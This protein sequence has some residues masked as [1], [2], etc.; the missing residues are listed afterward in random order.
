MDL[1]AL[2]EPSPTAGSPRDRV[3]ELEH[4][5]GEPAAAELCGELLAGAAPE[6]LDPA[7][8]YLAGAPVARLRLGGYHE[9]WFRVW[10][11]RGLLYVWSEGCADAV[12]GGL[13]DEHWRVA[14]MCLKVAAKRDL[15]AAA[16]AATRLTAHE[17]SRVRANAVRTLGLVGDTEHWETVRSALADPEGDVRRAAETARRRMADRLD[18]EQS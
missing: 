2:P 17:L 9:Y 7:I 5:L 11:A 12:L 8:R 16:P 1:R 3:A 4:H 6:P 18:L 10:G 15:P 13:T 14:E